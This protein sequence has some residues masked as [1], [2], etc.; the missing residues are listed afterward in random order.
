MI[1]SVEKKHKNS[2]I[3]IHYDLMKGWPT[4]EEAMRAVSSI[5][6]NTDLF[7]F[8]H[9]LDQW[10]AVTMDGYSNQIVLTQKLC[11][12]KSV[13]WKK[14]FGSWCIYNGYDK[15]CTWEGI[16]R[17]NLPVIK[18]ANI[19]KAWKQTVLDDLTKINDG[20]IHF[21]PPARKKA[22]GNFRDD[23]IILLGIT[24]FAEEMSSYQIASCFVDMYF[25]HPPKYILEAC[26]SYSRFNPFHMDI[27]YSNSKVTCTPSKLK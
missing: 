11:Y 20:Y 3:S 1:V 7:G 15:I 22:E 17:E 27:Y 25:T 2:M 6:Y 16:R 23:C 26:H 10:Y 18:S 9:L 4:F 21:I 5:G 19:D 13:K 14:Y 8:V 12:I 24:L